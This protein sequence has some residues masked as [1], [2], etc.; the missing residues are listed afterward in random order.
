[1]SAATAVFFFEKIGSG[2]G[3]H[4]YSR[5]T[6]RNFVFSVTMISITENLRVRVWASIIYLFQSHPQP[7]F[8]KC[9]VELLIDCQLLTSGFL[10]I[11]KSTRYLRV[12]VWILMFSYSICYIQTDIHTHNP[13]VLVSIVWLFSH[14]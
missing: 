10:M 4:L 3:L 13:L 7:P 14:L 2:G 5:R 1:M 6:H 8:R 11:K 12:W 9:P